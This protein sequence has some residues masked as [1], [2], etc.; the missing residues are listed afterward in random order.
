[1]KKVLTP[2]QQQKLAGMLER[3]KKRREDR[4]R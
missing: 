4:Y 3:F 1:M 2:D